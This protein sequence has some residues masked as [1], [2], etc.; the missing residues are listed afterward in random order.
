MCEI[1]IVYSNE[2]CWC[3]ITLQRYL[4]LL[5][6]QK[7]GDTKPRLCAMIL[8]QRAVRVIG[9]QSQLLCGKASTYVYLHAPVS[10]GRI[11]AYQT[12]VV[13]LAG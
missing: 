2:I 4:A 10:F 7:E 6:F 9:G 8:S 12:C 3:A 11:E 13:R 1:R 5:S